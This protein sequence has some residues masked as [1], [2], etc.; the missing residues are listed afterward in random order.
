M[1]PD[2]PFCHRIASSE[3]V[4][5]T[6]HA[7]AFPD[8]FPVSEGHTLIVPRRHVRSLWDL[9]PSELRDIWELVGKVR[10]LLTSKHSPDGFNVGVNDGAAA[11]QTIDHAHLH[12]I[13]RYAGDVPDPRGSIRFVLPD[14]AKYWSE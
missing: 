14:S 8:G 4:A 2:C 9:S 11:G 5:A 13:P 10:A 1:E 7:V 12:I 6:E 3:P